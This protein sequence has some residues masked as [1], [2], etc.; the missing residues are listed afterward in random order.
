VGL[1]SLSELS[2]VKNVSITP[3]ETTDQDDIVTTTFTVEIPIEAAVT[4]VREQSDDPM[5]DGHQSTTDPVE[6]QAA[7]AESNGD[8]QD[9]VPYYKNYDLLERVYDEHD[10]F[11]EMTA[12]LDVGVT[13]ATVR[14]HM[15]NHGIHPTTSDDSNNADTDGSDDQD[16]S[17]VEMSGS[18]DSSVSVEADGYGLPDSITMDSL[19]RVVQQSRTLYEAQTALGLDRSTTREI[20]TDLDLLDLVTSRLT[21][22]HTTELEDVIDRI[23]AASTT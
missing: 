20:L 23:H 22:D 21:A 15:V 11:A 6:S 2:A 13:P 1:N 3:C 16:T 17:D 19:V 4:A 12:A 5:N 7:E 8:E 10:T 9:D 14:E 18:N